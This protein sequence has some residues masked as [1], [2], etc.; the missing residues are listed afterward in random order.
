MEPLLV[1][2]ATV[3]THIFV[4]VTITF[5]IAR[6]AHDNSV[7]DI[8][9]GPIYFFALSGALFTNFNFTTLPTLLIACVGLWAARLGLRIFRKN[10]GK[11]ED[12]RYAKWREEWMEKGRLYFWLRSYLQINLLQGVIIFIVALPGIVAL[13]YATEAMSWFTLVG[14]VIF[15][16]GFLYEAT[17]D[18]QLDQFIHRKQAG[19]TDKTLMTEGLFALSRRP[20]YFGE[21]MVWTGLAFMVLPL[22]YGFIALLS[23]ITIS[24][25][26]TKVTGPML[27]QQFLEKYPDAYTHYQHTTNYIIPGPKQ[28]DS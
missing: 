16:F 3:A 20:N 2:S 23:P 22:P 5:I 19:E 21:C 10:K 28:H 14:L 12:A 11:P 25:I 15:A 13:S 4:L 6:L 24:Y 26:V 17:A 7:M 8:F 27:E 1:N 18:W 9:Y